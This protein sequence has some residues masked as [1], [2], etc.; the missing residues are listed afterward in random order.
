[1]ILR[2]N[3][4][5]LAHWRESIKQAVEPNGQLIASLIPELEL[6][7]GKQPPVPDLLHAPLPA[8]RPGSREMMSSTTSR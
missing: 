6:V 7:I 3:E 4:A 5:E 2:S 1:M 8:R